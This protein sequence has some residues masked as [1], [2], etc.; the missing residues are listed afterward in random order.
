M[1]AACAAYQV[2]LGTYFIVW[3]PSL[4]PEDVRFMRTSS[5][6]LQIAPGLSQWLQWVFAVMGGQMI[7]LGMLI[8]LV[9]ARLRNSGEVSR[10]ELFLLATAAAASVVLM[11]TVNFAIH[12]DFRFLLIIPVAMWIGVLLLLL[13]SRRA[14]H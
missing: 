4:L 1:L 3:R 8:L 5:E 10:L 6:A 9:A 7:A 14:D 11:S 2:A 12:S 13:L